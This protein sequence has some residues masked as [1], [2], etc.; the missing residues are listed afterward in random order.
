MK[1]SEIPKK[2]LEA[3]ARFTREQLAA[4]EARI[5]TPEFQAAID[6]ERT[7]M[8]ENLTKAGINGLEAMARF[9]ITPP[10]MAAWGL[11]SGPVG[12]AKSNDGKKKEDKTNPAWGLIAGPVGNVLGEL[13]KG[14][15]LTLSMLKELSIAMGRKTLIGARYVAGK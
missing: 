1:F 7:K 5:N 6:A 4:R 8:Y 13:A 3:T 14:G 11:I 12:I 15:K 2:G 10:I 9:T